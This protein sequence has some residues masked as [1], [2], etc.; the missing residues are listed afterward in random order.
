[1]I[2]ITTLLCAF[3]HHKYRITNMASEVCFDKN[4]VCVLGTFRCCLD[5][6]CVSDKLKLK[7][8][9]FDIAHHSKGNPFQVRLT[10]ST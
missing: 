9:P 6:K 4:T 1:M 3:L 8:T 10:V 7:L 5:T 2:I